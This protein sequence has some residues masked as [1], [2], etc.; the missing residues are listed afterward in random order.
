MTHKD[1]PKTKLHVGIVEPSGLAYGS[2]LSLLDILARLDRSRFEPEVIL[3]RSSPFS[4]KLRAANIPFR[5]LLSPVAHQ[6][7]K[8][9]R[10][11]DYVNLAQH[12]WRNR[13]DL[14]YVNQGG[15]LR[16]IALIARGLNLPLICQVQTLEDARWVSSLT[17]A[18]KQVFAFVCNSKF[19]EA[20]TKVPKD[21]VSMLY[22]GYK[23]KGLPSIKRRDEHGPLEV[24]LLGRI[25]ESKGHYL[26]VEAARRLKMANSTDYHFRFIGDAPTVPERKRIQDLV[27]TQELGQLIEF[28]GYK[29]DLGEELAALDLMVI[30]SLAEPFGRIYLEAAE[31]RLPVLVSDGGGLGELARHF[32]AGALFSSGNVDDFLEKL[33]DIRANYESHRQEFALAAERMLASLDLDEYVKVIEGMLMQ[34]ALRQPSAVVW[35]GRK[36][37]PVDT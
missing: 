28:R 24:G 34:T 33:T 35:R 22:L 2:E 32:H 3:P 36:V 15:I 11:L 26:V 5:E 10:A 4:E 20:E 12:W 30:P 1:I 31:A 16:P 27:S 13:P 8:L 29:T 25:C 17:G 37:F 14:V 23:M 9:G 6:T 21:R 19:I 18:H 7:G